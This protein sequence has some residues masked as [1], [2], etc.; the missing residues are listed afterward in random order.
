MMSERKPVI[1]LMG[2][3][4]TGKSTLSQ[5][6]AQ[7]YP[8]EIICTDSTT[9][10]KDMDIGTAKPSLTEQSLCPHHMLDIRLPNESY[11]A[12]EFK[13]DALRCIDGCHQRDTIPVLVG[14]SML[15]FHF[16][17]NAYS[18]LERNE[19]SV[20]QDIEDEATS[21]GWESLWQELHA[22]QPEVAAQIQPQDKQRISRALC[23]YRQGGDLKQPGQCTDT[24]AQIATLDIMEVALITTDRNQLRE[25]IR[26]RFQ[27]MLTAGLIEETQHIIR[28]YHLTAESPIMRTVGY[29]QVMAYLSNQMSHE[30]MIERAC[31][32]TG[33][34]AKRQHTWLNKFPDSKRF[35]GLCTQSTHRII[36]LIENWLA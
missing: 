18:G 1:F 35:D 19:Q 34:L 22:I 33:Q 12:G 15:Y 24:Q 30:E 7:T 5:Q 25:R 29:R 16:L 21:K 23:V 2:A 9:V 28:Q 31:I 17:K 36:S 11:S 6:L 4:A 20:L 26:Q 3:T 32:A 13:N 14:G 8:I 10:Y 27:S